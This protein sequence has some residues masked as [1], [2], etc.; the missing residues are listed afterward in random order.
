VLPNSS[1]IHASQGMDVWIRQFPDAARGSGV[2]AP[3]SI[4]VLTSPT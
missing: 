2:R 3:V 4:G 1:V